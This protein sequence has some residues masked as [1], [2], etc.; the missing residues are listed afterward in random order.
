V[1]WSQSGLAEGEYQGTLIVRGTASDAELRI[2]YWYAVISRTPGRLASFLQPAT[3]SVNG[4]A[5]LHV[6]VTDASGVILP[7]IQPEVTVKSGDGFPSSVRS[8]DDLY[9]GVWRIQVRMGP[10]PGP[11]VFV[12]KA[13]EQSLEISVRG[14]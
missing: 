13:G 2:P 4:T 9:P 3:A 7:D 11:N 8:V 6:R 10:F 5:T 12:V 14:I 1:R